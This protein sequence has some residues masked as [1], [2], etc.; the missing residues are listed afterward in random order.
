MTQVIAVAENE[1]LSEVAS[2]ALKYIA[3]SFIELSIKDTGMK[4]QREGM[5]IL[6]KRY[7]YNAR[8]ECRNGEKN[9]LEK[10]EL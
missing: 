8:I 4:Y 6:L 1:L 7:Y 3:N 5:V 9:V 2:N 10:S